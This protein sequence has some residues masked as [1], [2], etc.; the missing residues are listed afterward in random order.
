MKA[1]ECRGL[2]KKY[3][4]QTALD[5]LSFVIEKNKFYGLLGRNGAG[6]TT[7][8]HILN[9]EL[10]QSSG[11]IL[12]DGE[13]PYENRNALQKVC[14]IKEGQSFKKV[15]RVEDVCLVASIFYPN[16]DQDFAEELLETFNLNLKK[17]VKEL[18]KGM[19]SALGVTVGLASRAPITIFDEPYIGMDA[20]ARQKFYDLLLEEYTECPRTFILSTHLIDEVSKLFEEVIMIDQG[21]LLLHKNVEQLREEAFYLSGEIKAVESIG[22]NK[23]I[24]SKEIFGQSNTLGVY[25]R[26]SDEERK[27][28]IQLNVSI[29]H[30]PLQKLMIYL[31]SLKEK[32][33]HKDAKH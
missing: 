1:I 32:E 10:S 4:T 13:A 29:E 2:T 12:V 7:L 17:S 15:A 14:F 18:S 27:K 6:K 23:K 24:I 31:T 26:L 25:G 11:T 33:K 28:A 30:M 22:A 19:E 8:L 20:V 16:W 9:G 21:K 3:G 5:D